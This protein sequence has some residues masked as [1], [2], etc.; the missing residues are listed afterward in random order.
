MHDEPLQRTR[1]RFFT[2]VLLAWVPF[3]L[4]LVPALLNAFRGVATNKATGLGAVAGGFAESFVIFGFAALLMVEVMAIVFSARSF[5]KVS[6]LRRVLSVASICCSLLL[7]A[8]MGIFV[9]L[10]VYLRSFSR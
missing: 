8:T 7:I 3:F 5:S 2:G 9:W 10:V 1:N 6:G 4:F